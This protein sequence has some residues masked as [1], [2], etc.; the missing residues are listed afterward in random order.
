MDE[1]TELL[2]QEKELSNG[3]GTEEEEA[4]YEAES[5]GNDRKDE[6]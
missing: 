3:R 2:E 6:E 1:K 5:V 4:S